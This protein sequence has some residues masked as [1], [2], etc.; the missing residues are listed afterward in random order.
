M[1]RG[2]FYAIAS[3]F[4]YGP[5]GYFGIS[6][7]KNGASVY[8]MMFW[9]FAIASLFIAPFIS[10][11]KVSLRSL[12]KTLLLVGSIYCI[13]ACAYFTSGKTIGTGLAMVIFFTYPAIVA[14]LN[15]VL[16]G[17]RLDRIY[18]IA[19]G[20]ILLGMVFLADIRH[21]SFDVYGIGLSLFS[22]LCYAA[23]ILISKNT[24]LSPLLSTF[25]VSIGCMLT[26]LILALIDESFFIPQDLIVWVDILGIGIICSAVPILLF[27]ESMKYISAE[28]TSIFSVLEPVFTL[29]FGIILLGER[30]NM[31]QSI[32]IALLLSA[33]LVTLLPQNLK[34]ILLRFFQRFV[35]RP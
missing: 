10:L 31:Q 4:C 13:G 7:L 33:A 27:L 3:G 11:T 34:T 28:Q 12:V 6:I 23:Y 21:L 35:K 19:I 14:F 9:R 32:G 8:T 17:S 2:I 16:Y 24:P 22:G 20:M 15:F 26:A 18:Y 25:A 1:T 30:I 5:L 29:I